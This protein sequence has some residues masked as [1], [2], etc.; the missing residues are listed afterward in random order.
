MAVSERSVEDKQLGKGPWVWFADLFVHPRRVFSAMAS[1]E[2][3]VWLKPMLVLTA[4]VVILSLVG[5]PARLLDAQMGLGQPPDDFQYWSEEQ[6]NQFFEGQQAMQGP[7]FIYILPLLGSLVSLWLGW[8]I[9]GSVLHLLM[10]FRGSRQ[11][12]RAYLNLVAWAAVPFMLRCLVQIVALLT[13]RQVIDDPG[14]SGFVTAGE[15]GGAALLRILLGMVDVYAL[16]F[17]A[18]VLIGAPIIS[19]LKAEKSLWVAA[20]GLLVFVVLAALPGFIISQFDGLGTI[21]PFLL[22]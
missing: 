8:F 2:G 5:G 17:A 4:L 6:Q 1:I 10:T 16:G 9:L 12:Q 15:G 20:V 18:L 3:G 22:F 21:Q 14:L 13:T 11:P 19:G 7:L